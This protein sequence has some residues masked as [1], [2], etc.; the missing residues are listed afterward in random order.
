MS[1]N[2]DRIKD[3]DGYIKNVV[4]GY[5]HASQSLLPHEQNAYYIIPPL[6]YYLVIG[7]YHNPEY[8][9]LFPESIT[10]NDDKN[11]AIHNP[12]TISGISIFG[13]MKISKNMHSNKFIWTIKI[14]GPSSGLAIAIGIDADSSKNV[15]KLFDCNKNADGPFYAY[16]SEL[17]YGSRQTNLNYYTPKEQSISHAEY[18]VSYAADNED[19]T[20]KM[21]LNTKNKTLRYYVNGQDQGVAINDVMLD[22]NEEYTLAISADF[23]VTV[24]LLQFEQM[25]DKQ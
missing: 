12:Q 14:S 8:F 18:G 17:F 1:F 5:I 20:L 3:V 24:Q 16:E 22:N 4:N 6:I 19:H 11:K 13:N 9:A 7:Y 10:I 25:Y 15:E 21:E 23:N 2:F